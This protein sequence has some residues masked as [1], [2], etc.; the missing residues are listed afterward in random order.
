MLPSSPP[1]QSTR[2][3]LLRAGITAAIG[4]WAAFEVLGAGQ[5]SAAALRQ[6]VAP[7]SSRVS[8]VG[9]SLTIGTMPFQADAFANAGWTQSAVDAYV[10]R[11]VRTKIRADR[12]T[13]LTAVDAIREQSGDTQAWVIALGTN[14]AVIYS[15]EKQTQVIGLMMDH[16]GP[17]HRVLWVNVFLPTR[18]KLQTTW[19]TSLVRAAAGRNDMFVYDWAA[20]AAANPR[21]LAHDNIHYDHDGYRYRAQA[22]SLASRNLM[23]APGDL[24]RW[25]LTWEEKI[26]S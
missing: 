13:G 23:P 10:S 21:F 9:D 1:Q 2:R 20:F 12:Y 7:S 14:D 26:L 16:I 18:E 25:Q 17:G 6:P 19:N 22:V 11:G 8:L 15:P 24:P 4:S 5:A 3:Q